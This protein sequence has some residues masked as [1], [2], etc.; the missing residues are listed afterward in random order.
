MQKR[1]FDENTITRNVHAQEIKPE[2]LNLFKIRE[3]RTQKFFF[4]TP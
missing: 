2:F 3:V 1:F 4:E